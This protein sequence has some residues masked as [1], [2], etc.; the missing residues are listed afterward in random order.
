MAQFQGNELVTLGL[1]L[2]VAALAALNRARLREVPGRRWLFCAFAAL[3]GGWILTVLE[4]LPPEPWSR[5]L[6]LLEHS[7]YAANSVLMAG[8]CWVAFW[9]RREG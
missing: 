5:G 6:N 7:L 9:Q 3:M 8:W 1:A 4:S 2:T